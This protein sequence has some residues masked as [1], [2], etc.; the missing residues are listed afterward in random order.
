MADINNRVC[1][2]TDR[3]ASL[4]VV[5][6]L[7]CCFFSF[8][9]GYFIGRRQETMIITKEAYG[10]AFADQIA[11]SLYALEM[12]QDKVTDLHLC[13][14]EP[15]VVQEQIAESNESVVDDTVLNSTMHYYAQLIGFSTYKAATDCATNW[16]KKGFDVEVRKRESKTAKGKNVAWYQLVTKKYQNKKELEHVIAVLKK[17]EKLKD[18]HIVAC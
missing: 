1:T 9:L 18:V 2:V 14:D 3:Q 4:I 15:V 5:G 8:L 10:D 16:K 11:A 13:S 7:F 6:I 17:Q 12:P